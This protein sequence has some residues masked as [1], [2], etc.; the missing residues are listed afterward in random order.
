MES[1]LNVLIALLV[2]YHTRKLPS[3]ED[4]KA[5]EIL[6][7]KIEI[8]NWLSFIISLA[9]CLNANFANEKLEFY[10]ENHTLTIKS[11]Q[12]LFL[13]KECIKK[14]VKPASFAIAVETVS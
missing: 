13:A 2:K 4:V 8:V 1:I 9:K 10:Y 12:K 5:Y 11:H 3:F 7:P 6:L 14:L